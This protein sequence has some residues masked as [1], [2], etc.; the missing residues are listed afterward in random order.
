MGD[1]NEQL[2]HPKRHE[3]EASRTQ[4]EWNERILDKLKRQQEWLD[5]QPEIQELLLTIRAR[6]QKKTRQDSLSHG[7]FVEQPAR[8]R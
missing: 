7:T 3:E 5:K 2:K 4:E 8:G 1:R 6:L